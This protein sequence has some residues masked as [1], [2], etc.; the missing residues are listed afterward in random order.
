MKDDLTI[1]NKSVLL[2]FWKHIKPYKWYYGVMLLVPF[3]SGLHPFV[4]NYTLKLFLDVIQKYDELTYMHFWFPVAIFI[5]MQTLFD[6][7]WRINQLM[8]LRSEPFVRQSIIL[9]A[10]DQVMSYSY[11]FFQDNLAGTVNTK[12]KGIFDGYDDFWSEVQYGIFPRTFKIAV[13][14]GTLAIVNVPLCFFV[15]AWCI[16]YA[17][18]M[19][20]LSKK[21]NVLT[22]REV[23]S[24]YLLFGFLSDVITNIGAVFSYAAK[25][26]EVKKLNQ[27]LS[28]NLIPKQTDTY[29]YDFFVHTI[30]GTLQLFM[31][32]LILFYMIYLQ[33][34]K[35]TTIGDFAFVFG[36]ITVVAD[37]IWYATSSLPDFA[38][39]LG[40]LK[41]SLSILL[42]VPKEYR[43]EEYRHCGD[44]QHN[45]ATDSVSFEKPSI[46]FKDVSFSYENKKVFDN[47]TLEIKAGQKVGIVGYSGS[48]K[49]TLTALLLRYFSPQS[50]QICINGAD[51][52]CMQKD[53][54][55]SNIAII[56]QDSFLFNRSLLENIWYGNP[57]ASRQELEH[58]SSKAH[59]SEYIMSLPAQYDTC[60]GERG[61]KLSGGQR[62]RIAIARAILK[63]APIL[64]L[65]EATS[66]LDI[67]TERLVQES[68]QALI[69]NKQKT[70]IAIAHRLSTLKNMDRIIVLDKGKIVDEGT[71][72]E[73]L[74][75]EGG[76]YEKLWKY[77]KI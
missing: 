46:T 1:K 8:Q 69:Q 10:Y 20:F 58:A 52:A 54:L 47:L 25:K 19:Y 73:L 26:R 39:T 77:Q 62:Q 49:S 7:I 35:L 53:T 55:R 13:S 23:E 44:C 41:S 33:K 6:I 43:D 2:F 65:D 17:P 27:Y 22:H 72:Q 64:I 3:I 30:A 14:I 61:L 76:I 63:D 40:K 57:Q 31:F 28:E 12:L 29:K 56:P 45:D 60:A 9:D 11:R 74:D 70:V 36:I 67:Y 51:I 38:R 15:C 32:V 4:F 48:G 16:I 50:G 34:N 24:K 59:I 71:H 5:A 37:D 42:Q 18:T 68:L 66:S 21:L 75:K